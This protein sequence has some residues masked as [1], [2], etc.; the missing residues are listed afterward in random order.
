MKDKLNEAKA[1]EV[2]D[3]VFEELGQERNTITLEVRVALVVLRPS[4]LCSDFA[5][6]VLTVCLPT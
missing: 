3:K 2:A 6:F 4:W 1:K 5:L